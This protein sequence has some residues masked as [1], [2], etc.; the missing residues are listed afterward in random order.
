[1]KTNSRL[2]IEK[3]IE[4]R[5]VTSQKRSYLGIS[6][7][8]H[9][10]PR[11]LWYSFRWCVT[12]KYSIRID[13]LLKRGKREEPIIITY[14]KEIGVKIHSEQE[15]VQFLNGYIKGHIDG[16]A[17]NIPDAPKTPH[18][19]EF[20]TMGDR[21]FKHLSNFCL[22]KA[23]PEYYIQM[24]CYM[25][26]LKLKRGLLI[27]VNKN[28]DARYYECIYANPSKAKEY[29]N[30]AQN[31]ITNDFLPFRW[32]SYKCNWCNYQKV[33]KN[34]EKS[35][36]NCRTCKHVKM[37]YS[38]WICSLIEKPSFLNFEK[39]TQGCSEHY[40]LETLKK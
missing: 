19:L 22:E 28:D 21:Y 2:K 35:E 11:F 36:K 24:I 38:G 23:N 18:V 1:M 27:A 30:R 8:G 7:I 31:I 17:E 9:N 12:P 26:L 39:Q 32:E 33:C 10:C 3:Q 20:K 34:I 4:D 5:I 16:I 6:Q 37:D 40:F 14:L 13:R 25:E 15:E 29:L